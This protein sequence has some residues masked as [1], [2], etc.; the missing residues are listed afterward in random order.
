MILAKYLV[1]YLLT[2]VIFFALDMVW[3]GL[4]AKNMYREELGP[5]LK[6]QPNWVAAGIFYLLFILGTLIFAVYPAV[7]KHSLTSAVVLGALFG[8]FTYATYDLTNLATLKDWPLMISLVDIAWGTLLTSAV[9]VAGY[10]IVSF[11]ERQL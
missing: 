5:L 6:S 9:S 7:G 10:F 11:V 3:L 8:F 1:S 4:V 2:A